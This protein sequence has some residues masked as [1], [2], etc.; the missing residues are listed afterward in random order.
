MNLLV[1][2]SR[3]RNRAAREQALVTAASQ[4]FASLG[5]EATTTR[6]IA[7]RAACAEGLIHRYFGG[8][9]GLLLAIVQSRVSHEVMALNQRVWPAATLE[10]EIQQLVEWEIDRMWDDR[11]FLSVIIP[12][13]LLDPSLGDVIHRTCVIQRTKAIAE[14][15]QGFAE[16]SALPKAELDALAH[17]VAVTGFMFGFI[18]P[19]VVRQDRNQARE[20][21]VNLAKMMGRNLCSVPASQ[22]TYSPQASVR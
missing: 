13:A 14:R 6:E 11:E 7:A 16:C 3:T 12:R 9:A 22:P 17:F 10:E 8:K 1:V 21:A 5:F 4:L 20:M 18:R 2:K 19:V 15:L